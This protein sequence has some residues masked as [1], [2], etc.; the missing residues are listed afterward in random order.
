M[1]LKR[2]QMKI[3]NKAPD[4]D[5]QKKKHKAQKSHKPPEA[6][7]NVSLFASESYNCFHDGAL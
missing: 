7:I 5:K 4:V 6:S 3:F 1:L 2:E